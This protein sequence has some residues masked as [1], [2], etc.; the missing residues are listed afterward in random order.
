[1]LDIFSLVFPIFFL[2]MLGYGLGASSLLPEGSSAILSKFTFTI[3]IPLL[4]F[5]ALASNDPLAQ[6]PWRI[7]LG[8]FLC[9]FV[10]WLLAMLMVRWGFSR[11]GPV[12]VIAGVSAAFSNTVL[13]G[14]PVVSGAFGDE[15]LVP[16]LILLSIHLPV[17]MLATAI[18]VE[19]FA[20]KERGRGQ[21]AIKLDWWGVCVRVVT[22]LGK[23]PIIYGIFLGGFWGIFTLPIPHM[24]GLVIDYIVPMALPLALISMGMGLRHYG[25]RGNVAPGFILALLKVVA[26]PA[27]CYWVCF[28]LLPLDPLWA[29]AIILVSSSPTGVN[30]YL[31]AEQFDVGHGIAANSITLSVIM[32]FVTFPF[33]LWLIR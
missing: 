21:E 20:I 29:A 32:G 23:N 19:W 22:S 27:L 10:I 30:A 17:M 8:Y 14:I 7:W 3:P 6:A 26:F 33:W 28:F 24:V 15:G 16:V 4:I 25:L 11:K 9:V 18:L 2:I 5:R 13:F 31:L 1:M 12:L